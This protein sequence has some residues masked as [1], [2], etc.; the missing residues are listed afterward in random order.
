MRLLMF[1]LFLLIAVLLLFFG[2]SI[3][4]FIYDHLGG[5][6]IWKSQI[7]KTWKTPVIVIASI[8]GIALLTTAALHSSKKHEKAE[9]EFAIAQGWKYADKRNDPVGMIARVSAILDKVSHEKLYDVNTVMAVPHK[10]GN[11]YLFGCWYSERTPGKYKLGS[12]CLIESDGLRG[13]TS[14]VVITPSTGIDRAL[15]LRKVDM[16]DSEFAHSYVVSARDPAE[17]ARAVNEGLKAVLAGYRNSPYFNSYNFE[18][19]LGPGGAVILRWAQIPIEE[20]L[21][22]VDL[23]RNLETAM[24]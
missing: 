13:L 10:Q 15:T 6:S 8:A 22:M 1:L 19:T 21:P 24:H 18:I 2:S 17:A 23:A 12:G 11:L 9:K 16:G 7:W 4:T 5:L 14:Q 3:I 20:W